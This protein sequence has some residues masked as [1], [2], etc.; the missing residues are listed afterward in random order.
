M[1]H[2][3]RA[4]L[5]H[6]CSF[7][8]DNSRAFVALAHNT[9]GCPPIA[10]SPPRLLLSQ[11]EAGP[12]PGP[13]ACSGLHP[14]AQ[15]EPSCAAPRGAHCLGPAAAGPPCAQPGLARD[16]KKRCGWWLGG[17]RPSREALPSTRT[18]WTF[19]APRPRQAR[20]QVR[21]CGGWFGEDGLNCLEKKLAQLALNFLDGGVLRWQKRVFEGFGG[22]DTQKHVGSAQNVVS[23]GGV[24]GGLAVTMPIKNDPYP[25]HPPASFENPSRNPWGVEGGVNAPSLPI[26]RD[27]DFKS[28][29]VPRR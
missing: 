26:P 20:Q 3:T 21:Q 11:A 5:D 27:V 12:D 6:L 17:V 1:S 7:A 19:S 15:A 28:K 14:A 22:F 10:P 13:P 2:S 4:A 23:V 16:P 29:F 25:P 8:N 9:G 18:P 24:R